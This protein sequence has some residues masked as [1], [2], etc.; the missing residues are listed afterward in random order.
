MGDNDRRTSTGCEP[1]RWSEG[2][3]ALDEMEPARLCGD[4]E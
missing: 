1:M 3:R 4:Q 2:K